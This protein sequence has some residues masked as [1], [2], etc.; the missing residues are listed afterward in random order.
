MSK[1]SKKRPG[2][3]KKGEE[4]CCKKENVKMKNI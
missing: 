3:R 1:D 4:K 2:V